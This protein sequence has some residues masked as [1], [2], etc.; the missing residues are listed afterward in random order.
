MNTKYR[1]NGQN[2]ISPCFPSDF[3][4]FQLHKR[5]GSGIIEN[6]FFT[7]MNIH[8]KKTEDKY[9]GGSI[10]ISSAIY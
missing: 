3:T 7:W 1:I 5:L 9:D 8:L 4:L 2:Q 6:H 10:M